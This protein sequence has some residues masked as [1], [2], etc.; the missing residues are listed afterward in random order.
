MARLA[1][2]I[3]YNTI[4][5]TNFKKKVQQARGLSTL[6]YPL[7]LPWLL[8]VVVYVSGASPGKHLPSEHTM[9]PS[10][11]QEEFSRK[12]V[13]ASLVISGACK[14]A[15]FP[16]IFCMIEARYQLSTHWKAC[17]KIQSSKYVWTRDMRFGNVTE[18]RRHQS[19]RMA[20]R[21]QGKHPN[22]RA[23]SERKC[24]SA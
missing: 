24:D 4:T 21:C 9:K 11:N 5:T 15:E 8:C 3:W 14:K 6:L 10:S 17:S 12:N 1:T 22:R 16:R 18:N 23:E 13:C 19:S 2:K 20:V 7:P